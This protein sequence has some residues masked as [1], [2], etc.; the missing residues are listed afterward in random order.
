MS[1]S[2]TLPQVR[3]TPPPGAVAH[4]LHANAAQ[5]VSK[6]L[7]SLVSDVRQFQ[8]IAG[9]FA[10]FAGPDS[11]TFCGSRSALINS[12]G[13]DVPELGSLGE[14]HVTE[15]TDAQGHTWFLRVTGKWLIYAFRERTAEELAEQLEQYNNSVI[16]GVPKN[17]VLTCR[18]LAIKLMSMTEAMSPDRSPSRS[19]RRLLKRQIAGVAQLQFDLLYSKTV[20]MSE[21]RTRMADLGFQCPY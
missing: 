10:A 14:A 4:T 11:L 13:V 21:V 17:R 18:Y 1:N 15:A 5:G 12:H 19:A 6:P 2:D 3:K 7:L 8:G 9:P 20:P 16:S